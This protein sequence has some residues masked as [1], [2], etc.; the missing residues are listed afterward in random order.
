MTFYWLD[1]TPDSPLD[2]YDTSS[3]ASAALWDAA[4]LA[5]NANSGPVRF[6][7]PAGSTGVAFRTR[8]RYATIPAFLLAGGAYVFRVYAVR[9]QN[10]ASFSFSDI[11]V[12][13]GVPPIVAVLAGGDPETVSFSD[14]LV[15]DAS[16][17]YDPSTATGVPTETTSYSWMCAPDAA[18]NAAVGISIT[19]LASATGACGFDTASASGAVL[20]YAPRFSGFV[21]GATYRFT[22]SYKV[23][24]R[25]A[26]AMKAI[27]IA[28]ARP[29]AVSASLL[30]STIAVDGALPSLMIGSGA[31]MQAAVVAAADLP[32]GT[33]PT[34][35]WSQA[36]GPQISQALFTATASTAL[37]LGARSATFAVESSVLVPASTY[38]FCVNI[39]AGASG[40]AC[41]DFRTPAVPILGDLTVRGTG[42]NGA[43]VAFGATTV[44]LASVQAA[45]PVT[46]V[47]RYVGGH[48]S[49]T[50]ATAAA[51]AINARPTAPVTGTVFEQRAASDLS[52]STDVLPEGFIVV[53]VS[54]T[55]DFGAASKAVPVTVTAFSGTAADLITRATLEAASG[56]PTTT[57]ALLDGTLSTLQTQTA[58]RMLSAQQRVGGDR[59]RRLLT[60]ENIINSAIALLNTTIGLKI[61]DKIAAGTLTEVDVTD[62]LSSLS[63]LIDTLI[64]G[65]TAAGLP[66]AWLT[67]INAY[68]TDILASFASAAT[69]T[70]GPAAVAPTMLRIIT[71]LAAAPSFA[72]APTGGRTAADATRM[73]LAT[74]LPW[75]GSSFSVSLADAGAVGQ[76]A[77]STASSLSGVLFT[78]ASSRLPTA[79]FG[80]ISVRDAAGAA[81]ASSA[82]VLAHMRSGAEGGVSAPAAAVTDGTFTLSVYNAEDG[83]ATP[84]VIRPVASG[85][86]AVT[87]TLPG[88]LGTSVVA[89]NKL[90]VVYYN[91]TLARWVHS[92]VSVTSA[93]ASS[94]TVASTH[95]SSFALTSELP[96]GLVLSTSL[97][98]VAEEASSPSHTATLTVKLTT[99]P[100]SD[101]T[102]TVALPPGVCVLDGAPLRSPAVTGP[103]VTCT[104]SCTAAGA[105]CVQLLATASPASLT[106]TSSNF[107]TAQSITVTAITDSVAE[108]AWS[109][110]ATLSL[111][112]ASSDPRF[113]ALAASTA[114][115][116]ITD[117]DSPS[118]VI[119]PALPSRMWENDTET[120]TFAVSLASKPLAGVTVAVAVADASA[121]YGAVSPATLTFTTSDWS[122][123]QTLLVAAKDDTAV[124]GDHSLTI[125]IDLDSSADPVYAGRVEASRTI[126][127]A[128]NDVADVII[129]P[130]AARGTAVTELGGTFG[131]TVALGSR[132][133][134][135]V[136]VSFTVSLAKPAGAAAD[137]G[138]LQVTVGGAVKVGPTY[139]VTLTESN[140]AAGVA[141]SV[142]A[143]NDGIASGDY[144]VSLPLTVTTTATEYAAF[145]AAPR[146]AALSQPL[147]FRVQDVNSP[148]WDISLSDTT[149]AVG[150]S[151]VILSV[152]LKSPPVQAVT[153]AVTVGNAASTSEGYPDAIV[154]DAASA[155]TSFTFSA[156]GDD[157]KT[158]RQMS[159]AAPVSAFA[160]PRSD[161]TLKVAFVSGD[162]GYASLAAATRS[163][164]LTGARTPGLVFDPAS[165]SLKKASSD[166]SSTQLSVSLAARPVNATTITLSQPTPAHPAAP[167]LTFSPATITIASVDYAEAVKVT[168]SVAASDFATGTSSSTAAV[169]ITAGDAYLRSAVAI[170]AGLSGAAAEQPTVSVPVTI[171]DFATAA[172]SGVQSSIVT[173][174]GAVQT[175]VAATTI[176]RDLAGGI[177]FRFTT[178]PTTTLRVTAT[179]SVP[180][181][182]LL[183][184]SDGSQLDEDA[185][186]FSPD[187][188][189]TGA[190]ILMAW[191][192]PTSGQRP[193][194][195]VDVTLVAQPVD[196]SLALPT[197]GFAAVGGVSSSAISFSVDSDDSMPS[198]I[199]TPSNTPSI[200]VT[201]TATASGTG[202]G[203]VTASGTGTNTRTGSGTAT[204]TGSVSITAS[205]T[206]T[207]STT[208]SITA[209][210]SGTRTATATASLSRGTSPS[211]TPTTTGTTTGTQTASATG[212]VTQS[213]T[214]TRTETGT[215][216]TTGTETATASESATLTGTRSGSPSTTASNTGSRSVTATATASSGA[217]VLVSAVVQV[218]G[219]PLAQVGTASFVSSLED[220]MQTA[221]TTR[222]RRLQAAEEQLAAAANGVSSVFTGVPL[223]RVVVI[224][225]TAVGSG[226]VLYVN[227]DADAYER[228]TAAGARVLQSGTGS[229]TV[230]FALLAPS[231]ERAS[232]IASAINTA[233]ASLVTAFAAALQAA[234]AVTFGS[235]SAVVMGSAQ[236][237]LPVTPSPS[238]APGGGSDVNVGAIVGGVL[239]GVAF[240]GL[241]A[242]M[243]AWRNGAC[244]QRRASPGAGFGGGFGDHFE[245][246]DIYAET[247]AA[248]G[249]VMPGPGSGSADANASEAVAATAVDIDWTAGATTATTTTAK[250]AAVPAAASPATAFGALALEE[251]PFAA[252]VAAK[253]RSSLPL[254]S[255]ASPATHAPAAAAAAPAVVPAP[256]SGRASPSLLKTTR[257]ATPPVAVQAQPRPA[258]PD[259]LDFSGFGAPR[260]AP[261]PSAASAASAVAQPQAV[262][263]KTGSSSPSVR[264]VGVTRPKTPPR[265]ESPRISAV[266][267]PVAMMVSPTAAAAAAA[268]GG[269]GVG[270]PAAAGVDASD[271]QSVTAT[272]AT[273]GDVASAFAA[274]LTVAAA[275]SPA[276]GAAASAPVSASASNP[277]DEV[278]SD[279]DKASAS[280]AEAEEVAVL[281]SVD[282]AAPAP[283]P[284]PGSA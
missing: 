106:F 162:A 248:H 187:D 269:A 209:S 258:T 3:N 223:Q 133:S 260:A 75:T 19:P 199:P 265:P 150:G 167:V 132:P 148:A 149:V 93:T 85:A 253:K 281:V 41:V 115:V 275:L 186:I 261:S 109:S 179:M 142:K 161:Y 24:S 166:G 28:T 236:L 55:S 72:F 18:A 4:P 59:G 271:A 17:S 15:L 249:G 228:Y 230:K 54:A 176:S 201:G 26:T 122:T 146:A 175:G 182:L 40:S 177:A 13:I 135:A 160:F 156:D 233:P 171:A 94:I 255:L 16:N 276:A 204:N 219:V 103:A 64:A 140:Y 131:F 284:E 241:V 194:A 50:A 169:K 121:D 27:R 267:P 60:D 124:N 39:V 197:D 198:P 237:A 91:E 118:V 29:L 71:T 283:A 170:A 9:D 96:A 141:V 252:S 51:A 240:L 250:A 47:F 79:S 86:T 120:R 123:G 1:V 100:D 202:S 34:F 125:D 33:V 63:T 205:N 44:T 243:V 208:A 234:D 111:S 134:A 262:P 11:T 99:A 178:K 213:A 139:T 57:G 184:A 181:R 88:S 282:A 53:L 97:L 90:S 180:D 274:E 105:V 83:A 238:R 87:F 37:P 52:F 277:F 163:L 130:T 101:V 188:W 154:I 257:P 126:T 129:T 266:P 137:A 136:T 102:V 76:L 200:S 172:F 259:L 273:G 14:A 214:E 21:V 222:T 35:S 251:D 7:L 30:T 107:A 193:A 46:L 92:G 206:V 95:L 56:D 117:A 226:A 174:S 220:A 114:T 216:S 32:E 185:L 212:T 279:E 225:I 221:I 20:R 239:G 272:A 231:M 108:A 195:T 190:T 264:S 189:T 147:F 22:V 224:R 70:G 82:R 217:E 155:S 119:T 244:G 158:P 6:T 235:V 43:V 191:V 211:Y 256:S 152:A 25:T 31:R 116:M 45:D 66:A 73:A 144:N 242:G 36:A 58:R 263:V 74:R 8:Q 229:V 246:A 89:P 42:T 247:V 145:T 10:P 67:A 48:A 61:R 78:P 151:A 270:S 153:V 69:F 207:S 77:G 84:A 68:I 38:R 80:T 12:N 196:A 2:P 138:K 245:P 218:G 104:D 110:N 23:G 157:Y 5:S 128:D 278:D 232:S 49:A 280:A 210:P 159:L 183:V 227:P 65:R 127:L 81:I 62:V 165:L 98:S 192:P 173:A 215:A 143:Q 168:V 164:T 113:S 254:P 268:A 203:T 112:A